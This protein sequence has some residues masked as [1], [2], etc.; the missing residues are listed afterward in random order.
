MQQAAAKIHGNLVQVTTRSG[1]PYRNSEMSRKGEHTDTG[2]E[3]DQ[4]EGDS[5]AAVGLVELVRMLREE[6]AQ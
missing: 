1:L 6:Q 3:D 5:A 2:S 4:H